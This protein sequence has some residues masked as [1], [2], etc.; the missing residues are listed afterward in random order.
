MV[1]A[2]GW[3]KAFMPNAA[4]RGAMAMAFQG[5]RALFFGGTH[6]GM[7]QYLLIPFFVG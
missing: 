4:H 5:C 2:F 1:A 3:A 6:L 7:G